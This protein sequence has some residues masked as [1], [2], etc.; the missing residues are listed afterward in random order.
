MRTG[1]LVDAGNQLGERSERAG[2]H[3]VEDS[4]CDCFRPPMQPLDIRKA[5]STRGVLH[6]ADLLAVGINERKAP[7]RVQHGQRQTGKSR[8]GANIRHARSLQIRM[9]GETVEQMMSQHLVAVADGGEVVGAV[10][11]LQL[12]E[13]VNEPRGIRITECDTES[14]GALDQVFDYAQK[15]SRRMIAR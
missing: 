5:Q 9:N 7:L 8:A 3:G 4:T 6:K 13:Q 1:Q 15:S 11:A 12:I 2:D 14:R 10:P